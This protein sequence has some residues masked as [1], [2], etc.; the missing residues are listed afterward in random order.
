MLLLKGVVI[1][2]MMEDRAAKDVEK[3]GSPRRIK[4]LVPLHIAMQVSK[5]VS[6]RRAFQTE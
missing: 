2:I 1:C 6:P 4:R 3:L 5:V